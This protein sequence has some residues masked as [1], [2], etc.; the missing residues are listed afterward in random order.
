[1]KPIQWLVDIA[2]KNPRVLNIALL[3]TGLYVAY[4]II[5]YQ[6]KRIEQL[7]ELNRKQQEYWQEYSNRRIDSMAIAF[8]KKEEEL[9]A[10][11]KATLNLMLEDY[12]RQLREQFELNR[13]INNSITNNEVILRKN[14]QKLKHLEP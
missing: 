13:K 4:L 14:Q 2:K 3:L 9:N 6:Q 5:N 1:M 7:E 11:T 8:H 12:R 10:E